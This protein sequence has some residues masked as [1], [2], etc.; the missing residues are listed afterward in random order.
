[1]EENEPEIKESHAL[2]HG[3][4][5]WLDKHGRPSFEY[6]KSLVEDGNPRALETLISI[7]DQH[8][9]PYDSET[10]PRELV[11]QIILALQQEQ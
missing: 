2:E 6:L 5:E 9:V 11:D 3:K 10:D 7:A 8:D 1:M 4:E